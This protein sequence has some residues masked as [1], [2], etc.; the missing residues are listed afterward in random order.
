MILG[1]R[2]NILKIF[3]CFVALFSFRS[4][5]DVDNNKETSFTQQQHSVK[6]VLNLHQLLQVNLSSLLVETIQQNNQVIE[7]IFTMC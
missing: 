6:L 5:C 4:E 2:S 1:N 7:W 3:F